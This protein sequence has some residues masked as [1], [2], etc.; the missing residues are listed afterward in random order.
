MKCPKC[1]LPLE[2]QDDE[3]DVNVTGGWCC[4]TCDLFIPHWDIDNEE[5]EQ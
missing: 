1:D 4:D 5:W 2:H 3:P